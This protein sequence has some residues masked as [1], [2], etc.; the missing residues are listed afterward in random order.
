LSFLGHQTGNPRSLQNTYKTER[1][2]YENPLSTPNIL[3]ASAEAAPQMYFNPNSRPVEGRR[4]QRGT[5]R[6]TSLAGTSL[7][8]QTSYASSEVEVKQYT[9]Y[10]QM[11]YGGAQFYAN[12]E[13]HSDQIATE[14]TLSPLSVHSAEM[15][16]AAHMAY[17]MEK[18][19]SIH[20]FA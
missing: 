3:S 12:R 5:S 14:S 18:E 20:L 17:L 16:Q 2:R 13:K 6:N 15:T 8:D 19:F 11:T 9:T 4:S 7:A 10:M 1:T